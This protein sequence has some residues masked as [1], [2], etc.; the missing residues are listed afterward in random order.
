MGV[1]IA[2]LLILGM[3]LLLNVLATLAVSRDDY[4]E[5]RQKLFQTIVVW[6]VPILGALLLLGIHRKPE[7]PSRS[8]RADSDNIGD[9]FGTQRPLSKSIGDV[10]DGD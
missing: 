8:Y 9:D 4:A 5:P 6:V 1:D 7:K 2:L 10:I 3:V